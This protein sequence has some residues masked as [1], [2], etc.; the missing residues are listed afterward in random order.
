MGRGKRFK[1]KKLHIKRI[2]ILIIII[3]MPVIINIFK[4]QET[5]VTSTIVAETSPKITEE[6]ETTPKITEDENKQIEEKAR[7]EKIALNLDINTEVE[8][9]INNIMM[10][11]NLDSSNFAFFFQIMDDTDTEVILYN[12][13]TWMTAG[14]TIKVPL[15]MSYYD[16]ITSGELTLDTELLYDNECY[17]EGD[18]LTAYTYKVGDYIPINFL[19]KQMI[20]NSDNTAT[21]ILINKLGYSNYRMEVAK[22]ASSIEFP[23][24]FYSENITS[25]KYGYEVISYLYNH[26]SD[27]IELIDDMKN[28][29]Y[30]E[31]LK[32]YIDLS[33]IAHKYGSYNGYVHDYGIVY[34]EK[35]Y[36]IGIF[37]KNVTNASEVIGLMSQEIYSITE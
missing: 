30:G 20:V 7:N 27:Y 17:E 29:S 19:L 35:E 36:I 28:S 15:A 23:E 8:E 31:Y 11:Y 12:E 3:A 2:I 14:S 9:Y 4:Y 37:T 22:F 6:I 5:K 18:G 26:Q 24:N 25:A 10:E 33:D 16:K 21:N 1:K 13:E 34:G 32:K